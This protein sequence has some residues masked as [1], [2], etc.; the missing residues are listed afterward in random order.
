VKFV[1]SGTRKEGGVIPGKMSTGQ[2]TKGE[3]GVEEDEGILPG[4]D[5]FG[6]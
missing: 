5:L 4:G 2:V 6:R 1:T 3:G